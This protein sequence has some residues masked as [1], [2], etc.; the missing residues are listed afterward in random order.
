MKSYSL[1][2]LNEYIKRVLALNFEE[3]IWVNCE[4]TQAKA[5]KGNI[6]LELV[7]QEEGIIQAQANAI[8]WN[9]SGIA[10]RKKLGSSLEPILRVGSQIKAKVQVSMNERY[11]LKLLIEDIDPSYTL[12]QLS[13]KRQEILESLKKEGLINAN[14][15][16]SLPPVLQRIAVISSETA[17]GYQDFTQ[18][19]IHNSYGY[20][21]HTTLF[22]AAMQGDRTEEEVTMALKEVGSKENQF[23]AVVIIRGGGSKLDLSYFDS[24]VIGTAIAN[25][26]IPVITGIGHDIDQAVA[27]VVAH[28][29]LKTPT[30]VADYLIERSLIFESS[31]IDLASK[32]SQYSTTR[33]TNSQLAISQLEKQILLYTQSVLQKEENDLQILHSTLV[34]ESRMLINSQL[35]ELNGIEKILLLSDPN[36]VLSKGYAVVKK[37]D[38]FVVK[39]DGLKKKDKIDLYF[40]DGMVK[41][42]I[43]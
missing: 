12:G 25:C 20:K 43:D 42:T 17:A 2:E 1:F 14:S 39:A 13:V 32:A 34:R 10:L 30:S 26:P 8:I 21:Y 22:P 6:Y 38:T 36:V 23:D 11:G 40:N 4:I 9:K 15:K 5:A 3:P 29:A 7:Q 16:Q 18:H 41:A 35:L 37:G 27:D 19:L 33:I 28:T 24:K 31:V